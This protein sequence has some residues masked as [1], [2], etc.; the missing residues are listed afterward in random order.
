MF[1]VYLGLVY[2]IVYPAFRMYPRIVFMCVLCASMTRLLC[3]RAFLCVYESVRMYV[4][5]YVCDIAYLV[6]V[7]IALDCRMFVLLQDRP[8]FGSDGCVRLLWC[9][10]GLLAISR[11]GSLSTFS[12]F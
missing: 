12:A 4:C 10:A 11:V 8:C 6:D 7:L 9:F 2:I 3:V 5:M 1:S